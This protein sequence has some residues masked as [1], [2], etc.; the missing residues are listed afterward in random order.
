[1]AN[2]S[3]TKGEEE[4]MDYNINEVANDLMVEPDDLR[5]VYEAYFI[6]S[7][8]IISEIKTALEDNDSIKLKKM[9]HSLKGS[10]ANL[11]MDVVADLARNMEQSAGKNNLDT[12]RLQM[13]RVE[14]EISELQQGIRNFY[15]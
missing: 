11:R 12:I 7:A 2:I 15:R 14:N 8:E 3:S 5:E 9:F 4:L 10:S 1:M 13:S 6:E